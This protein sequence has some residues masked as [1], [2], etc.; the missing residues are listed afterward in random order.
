MTFNGQLEMVQGIPEDKWIHKDLMDIARMTDKQR[1]AYWV[2]VS[3]A[4]ARLL[5]TKGN[6][7]G[8]KPERP[9]DINRMVKEHEAAHQRAMAYQRQIV[10]EDER[11]DRAV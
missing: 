2:T 1:H 11:D 10:E 5:I 8:E 3:T 4:Q 6:C 7:V 9:L